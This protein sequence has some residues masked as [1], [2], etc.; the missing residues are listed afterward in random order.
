MATA[1]EKIASVEV[2]ALG[3]STIDFTSIPSTFTDL[4]LKL[5]IRNNN[6]TGGTFQNLFMTF[7]GVGTGYSGRNIQAFG[8]GS[9]GSSTSTDAYQGAIVV[10]NSGTTAST[11]SNIDIYIPNYAGS[12]QKPVSTDGVTESNITGM[13][14]SMMA[15]NSTTTS[16]ISSISFTTNSGFSFVQYSTATLYGIKKA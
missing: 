2:G 6:A 1:F 9:A 12:T 4:N 14:M 5:S 13:Y 10:S 3:A 11:F 7:N 16:A 8:S 15:F